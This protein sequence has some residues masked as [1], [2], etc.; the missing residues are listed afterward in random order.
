MAEAADIESSVRKVFS[1]K[2]GTVEARAPPRMEV[3]RKS[4]RVWSD[5]CLGVFMRGW[6]YCSTKNAQQS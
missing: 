5:C 2:T 6:I 1:R 4:R 3:R